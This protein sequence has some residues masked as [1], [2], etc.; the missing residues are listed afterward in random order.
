M[1]VGVRNVG[2]EAPPFNPLVYQGTGSNFY[3][4]GLNGRYFYGGVNAKF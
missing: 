3:G 4:D 2:D 1:F